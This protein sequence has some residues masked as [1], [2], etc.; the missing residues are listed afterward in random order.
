MGFLRVYT[1]NINNYN[2]SFCRIVDVQPSCGFLGNKKNGMKQNSG[3]THNRWGEKKMVG[4][5]KISGF[6]VRCDFD[7]WQPF[8]R[9]KNNYLLFRFPR[10]KIVCDAWALQKKPLRKKNWK[11]ASVAA[12]QN[13]SSIQK[14]YSETKK[15]A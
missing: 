6:P 7:A 12:A 3:I 14:Q 10:K 5:P 11:E 13:A 8:G 4:P 2:I 15:A 9:P 1:Y